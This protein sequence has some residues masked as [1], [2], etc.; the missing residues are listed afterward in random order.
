MLCQSYHCI[1]T[2]KIVLYKMFILLQFDYFINN[3]PFKDNNFYD[4]NKLI[5]LMCHINFI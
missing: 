2:T 3:F 5:M 4:N 1:T